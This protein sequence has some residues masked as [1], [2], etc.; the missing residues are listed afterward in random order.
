MATWRDVINLTE[1]AW[2]RRCWR[3]HETTADGDHAVLSRLRHETYIMRP[4]QASRGISG[5][6]S[7]SLGGSGQCEELVRD[8]NRGRV[9]RGG[10]RFLYAGT[11]L[12]G[13]ERIA[14]SRARAVS[15]GENGAAGV[16]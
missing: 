3:R 16:S 11:R 14:R 8:S 13:G 6:K 10:R 4:E 7:N 12:G 15:S 1:I 5:S 2:R 9:D